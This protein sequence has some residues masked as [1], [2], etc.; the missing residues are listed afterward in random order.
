MGAPLRGQLWGFVPPLISPAEAA[1]VW[2]SVV[3]RL[4][5]ANDAGQIPPAAWTGLRSVSAALM[6]AD[7]SESLQ[8]SRLQALKATGMWWCGAAHLAAHM[9]QRA[10]AY[11]HGEIPQEHI[12]Y[13]SGPDAHT[14]TYGPG[15]DRDYF[16]S[17]GLASG[18]VVPEIRTAVATYWGPFYNRIV[19]RTQQYQTAI[20]QHVRA[21]TRGRKGSRRRTRGSSARG[22]SARGSSAR[23]SS[24]R[25]SSAR[26]APT[27]RNQALVAAESVVKQLAAS[28][29]SRA[30]SDSG[31][32]RLEEQDKVLVNGLA[33]LR[34]AAQRLSQAEYR[35]L[36][37]EFTRARGALGTRLQR[38]GALD[39]MPAGPGPCIWT[40]GPVQ[41]SL[42]GLARAYMADLAS[43]LEDWGGGAR[44]SIGRCRLPV[45]QRGGTRQTQAAR[46]RR[47]S[48]ARETRRRGVQPDGCIKLMQVLHDAGTGS[49][50]LRLRRA[51]GLPI[52][53]SSVREAPF[54][55]F[56][57]RYGAALHETTREAKE[58]DRLFQSM[59]RFLRPA[60]HGRRW[61]GRR[62]RGGEDIG[63]WLG[64]GEGAPQRWSWEQRPAPKK[65][66]AARAPEAAAPDEF[67]DPITGAVMDSPVQVVDAEGAPVM[68]GDGP[69]PI[70]DR[71]TVAK[72][73]G[74][75]PYTQKPIGSA[76]K[77]R[78]TPVASL[79]RN[80]A[81]WRRDRGSGSGS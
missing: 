40:D 16:T 61:T 21:G 22:S 14:L 49:V 13:G 17:T 41:S 51:T 5:E 15:G 72:L 67:L 1:C 52:A 8:A 4:E 37:R 43:L 56:S 75:D 44:R 55:P 39:A 47:R 2:C 81:A 42:P 59:A 66:S 46:E 19:R 7:P 45:S 24:A 9:F 74:V 27:P 73:K 58:W 34:R 79:R 26:R 29:K 31:R 38:G 65:T 30:A 10:N 69:F 70:M 80:I 54:M 71:A 57:A 32:A 78:A 53:A 3:Q 6:A 64:R 23:G 35:R 12:G 48:R 68:H 28:S 62:E 77:A 18:A 50:R 11:L 33:A 60:Q 63:A 20:R 25:G 36:M 76:G